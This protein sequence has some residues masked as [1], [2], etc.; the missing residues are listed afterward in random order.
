VIVVG[1]EPHLPYNRPPLSKQVLAGSQ[2]VEDCAFDCAALDVE[3]RL[4]VGATSLDPRRREIELAD[5]ARLRYARVLLATGARARAWPGTS[6]DLE[7]LFTVRGLEDAVALRAALLRSPRVAVIGAGFVGC[8]VAASA[9]TLGLDV[10][11]IDVAEQPMVPLGPE[12]GARC[13][14]LHRA[15]GVS[16][17]LGVG[18]AGFEGAGRLESVRLADGSRV[19]ADVGVVAL[20]AAPNTEWLRG[21]GLRLEPGVSCDAT[22]M[23]IGAEDVFCAGDITAWPHPLAGGLPIRVEHW[24]TAAEQGAV[25]GRNLVA[26]PAAREPYTGLPSF[27]SDQYDVKI[28]AVGLPGHAERMH[29]VEEREDGRLV[30]VGERGGLAVAAVAFNAPARLAWYRRQL[31]QGEALDVLLERPA[32]AASGP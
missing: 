11:L 12:L 18:V 25:A 26:D 21:S 15:R 30:A 20:G 10:T 9:R 13:A 5:G 8:E 22:L 14:A 27:W 24:A 4:G 32:S 29:V 2:S 23:A 1:D 16:L 17:R 19:P 3:W 6:G 28:Q 31:A 7:G